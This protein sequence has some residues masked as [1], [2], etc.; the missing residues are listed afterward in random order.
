MPI[1]TISFNGKEYPK[2]QSEHNSARWILPFAQYYCKGSGY[3]IGYSKEEWKLPG[4]I[5]IDEA[6]T[7]PFNAMNL[8]CD[9]M[10]FLF[11][12]NCLEHVK[13]NWFNILDYW[14][15]KIKTGGIIFLY[16]P[17][18]SQEYWLPE[19]NR[20]HIHSF[21]GSEIEAYLKLL[22]HKVIKSG[23]DLNNSFVVVCEKVG[24]VVKIESKISLEQIC[25]EPQ[26]KS[27]VDLLNN[28]N[29]NFERATKRKDRLD[30]TDI[31]YPYYVSGPP[32]KINEDGFTAKEIILDC[33]N[34]F[35]ENKI[36][37]NDAVN[38]IYNN[39][40]GLL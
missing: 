20:K 39:I 40:Q 30:K 11:S 16:L 35:K 5:G 24:A 22:G 4:S 26:Y 15:T 34:H 14:L 18:K 27:H 12:S 33:L 2:F 23:V 7:S 32:D 38:F 25:A 3:D 37:R 10:D 1:E 29:F 13:E 17:H 9:N 6:H 19:N 31:N 21:D 36:S 28:L 8:P